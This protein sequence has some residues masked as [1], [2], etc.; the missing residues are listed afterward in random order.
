V[1]VLTPVLLGTL[2]TVGATVLLDMPF[3]FANVI[4]LPLLLG[5][6]VDNGMHIVHRHRSG[7]APEG[8]LAT[9]TARAVV[10][11]ALTTVVTF[12]NLAFSSHPGMASMGQLLAL[13]LALGLVCS[14]ITLPALLD[15]S[16]APR[17]DGSAP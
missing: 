1:L 12:G 13:G 3:N 10:V 5:I 7:H 15:W 4:A 11:S 17:I 16:D 2:L 9:S 14:L 8:V 6:C